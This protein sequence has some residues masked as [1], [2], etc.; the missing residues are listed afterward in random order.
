MVGQRITDASRGWKLCDVLL[1]VQTLRLIKYICA[2]GSS[3]FKRG[4]TKQAGPVRCVGYTGGNHLGA[5]WA[6]ERHFSLRCYNPSS[7]FAHRE[8]PAERSRGAGS[9][10]MQANHV[11]AAHRELTH[12]RGE[13]DPFKGDV[14]NQRVRDQAKEALEAIFAAS[15]MSRSTAP[16][17][18]QVRSARHLSSV[19]RQAQVWAAGKRSTVH[20]AERHMCLG[21]APYLAHPV[22]DA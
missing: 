16:L 12:F 13:P 14:V 9:C 10:N 21:H 18:R 15:D 1:Y 2:K 11:C 6:L 17:P 3:E 5:S 22:A 7:C 4:L 19:L 20:I 8:A